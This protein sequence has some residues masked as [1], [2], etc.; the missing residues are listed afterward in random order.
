MKILYKVNPFQS[1]LRWK[2]SSL[3]AVLIFPLLVTAIFALG[4][5]VTNPKMPFVAPSSPEAA[6]L[7]KFINYPVSYNVGLPDIS[8]PLYEIKAGDL[9]IPITLSYH[10]GGNKVADKGSWVGL[11]WSL[12]INPIITRKTNGFNDEGGYLANTLLGTGQL[13]DPLYNERIMNGEGNT[14]EDPDDFYYT[15]LNKSARFNYRKDCPSCTTHEISTFPYSQDKIID[16]GNMIFDVTD[17]NGVYYR[18]GRSLSGVST[19]EHNLTGGDLT[20]KVTEIIAPNSKDTIYF[21]YQNFTTPYFSSGGVNDYFSIDV[22]DNIPAFGEDIC[23]GRPT[24][25]P[26]ISE[27]INGVLYRKKIVNWVPDN[28]VFLTCLNTSPLSSAIGT[29][30]PKMLKYIYFPGGYL[31]ITG[32]P[33]RLE[34]IKIF[35]SNDMVKKEFKFNLSNNPSSNGRDVLNSVEI[36][37]V[38]GDVSQKYQFGYY[39]ANAVSDFD[40]RTDHWGYYNGTINPVNIGQISIPTVNVTATTV[41]LVY[42]PTVDFVVGTAIKDP[43]LSDAKNAVLERII[44]PTGGK[45]EFTY[46]LNQY[47]DANNQLIDAGG[48]RIAE[49]A[50]YDT[51]SHLASRRL[52]KY[53]EG[54]NGAGYIKHIPV[55][56]DYLKLTQKTYFATDTLNLLLFTTRQIKTW[57]NKSKVDLFHTGG[58]PVVYPEVTEYTYTIDPITYLPKFE[59]GK[60]VYKYNVQPMIGRSINYDRLLEFEY[61]NDNWMFGELLEKT[62]YKSTSSGFT[63]VEKTEYTY[64]L[65][66]YPSLGV[67]VGKMAVKG[68]I[69]G[70]PNLFPSHY[71]SFIQISSMNY[72]DV[73]G[74]KYKES[75]KTTIYNAGSAPVITEKRYQYNSNHIWATSVKEIAS[76]KDTLTTFYN[77]AQDLSNGVLIGKNM[78]SA[79][80]YDWSQLSSP[81]GKFVIG[82]NKADYILQSGVAV[83]DKT[84][85]LELTEP[86]AL[87]SFNGVID[88]HFKEHT[89]FKY[90]EKG[91]LVEYKQINGPVSSI[92]WGYKNTKPV[93]YIINASY[94]VAKQHVNES[95]LNQLNLS[96]TQMNTETQK[97]RTNLID[98]QVTTYSYRPLV[99]MET[100]TDPKGVIST[101]EYDSSLRLKAIKDQNGKVVKSFD[102]HFRP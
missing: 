36:K 15:L 8:V 37:D 17:E 14:D 73:P 66:T 10:A 88:S 39:N 29:Q 84:F 90:S 70:D 35:D 98:A 24:S 85:Q 46:E 13:N 19:V 77:Y 102:Y 89:L 1:R 94:D 99:G 41:D 33:Y 32:T 48:L 91:R 22:P 42:P 34:K 80:V 74:F 87:S 63:E 27:A 25:Y 53:G 18:F 101:Y 7:G 50:E 95:Y 71:R 96:S 86:L 44:F 21:K 68:S 5:G 67:Y 47:M 61:K 26:S 97:L 43:Y 52:F 76:N 12:Q 51:Q 58:A 30:D 100:Q 45:T 59:V 2:N 16:H 49:I 78:L 3:K 40:P 62:D 72:T 31:E 38:D 20:S 55:I 69:D 75:E 56:D 81:V 64:D 11:G 79:L 92:I 60:T 9:V 57:Y 6:T 54:G 82:G 65:R 93:A 4:Q 23:A 83:V 28:V